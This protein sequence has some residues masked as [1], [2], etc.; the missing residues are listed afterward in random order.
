MFRLDTNTTPA[1]FTTLKTF[2][3]CCITS[4]SGAWPEASLVKGAGSWF[5][6]TARV[7]GPDGYGTAFAVSDSGAFRLIASFDLTH[8][9]SPLGGMTLASDGSFYGVTGAG[10]LNSGGVIYRIAADTDHDGILDG[11]DNCPLVPNVDQLDTVGNGIG[12]VCRGTPPVA[13]TQSRTT[14]TS[15]P[16]AVTL[17]ASDGDGDP[18]TF[19]IVT[20]PSHGTLSGLAPNVTYTAG[21]ELLRPGQLYVQGQ[22][23]HVRFERRHGFDRRD[24]RPGLRQPV[25]RRHQRTADSHRN[26]HQLSEPDDHQHRI[27]QRRV[28]VDD[29]VRDRPA[30]R[31]R[32]ARSA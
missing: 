25:H 20:G 11:I 31:D 5:Y 23:R 2:E 16:L 13:N 3:Q 15:A 10:G 21:R 17:T 22:R 24:R 6:G 30:C 14:P 7:G 27:D 32:A 18:L 1:T 19:A 4:P 29:D 28:P 12:D 8:G 9:A 26:Q